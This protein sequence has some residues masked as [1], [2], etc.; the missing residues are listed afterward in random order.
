MSQTEPQVSLPV[1]FVDFRQH[2]ISTACG[3][4]V[5][6][7]AANPTDLNRVVIWC[8]GGTHVHAVRRAL[9]NAAQ[10]KKLPGLILPFIGS[11]R[12]WLFQR[13]PPEQALID[14]ANKQLLLMEAIRQFP[15]L[16]NTANAWL[17]AKELVGLFD[18]CT[19]AQIP[20]HAEPEKL[21]QL[22]TQAYDSPFKHLHNISRE[23]ETIYQ[24]WQAYHAQIRSRN[25][26]DP[27]Q[28]YCN[29]LQRLPE[30]IEQF[31]FYTIGI[32]RLTALETAYFSEL[33]QSHSLTM[34]YANISDQQLGLA[35]HPLHKVYT[36]DTP[37]PDSKQD[38]GLALNLVYAVSM[39]TFKRIEWLKNQFSANPFSNC[40]RLYT[41]HSVENHANAICLQT[42]QWLL[43]E[44]FP[45]GIV[46]NDRLLTRRIRAVLEDA[47][48]SADDLGGWA[49]STTS[50]ATVAEI[51]LDAIESNFRKD[52]LFDLLG[53]PFLA[54]PLQSSP[55]LEQVNR[56]RHQIIRNRSVTRGGISPYI[57]LLES[58][59]NDSSG[60][61]LLEILRSIQ[62]HSKTLLTQSY[63][64]EIELHEFLWQ[65]IQL[66]KK[67]NLT[68]TLA[69]DDAGSIILSTLE[70]ALRSIQDQSIHLG[71]SE[72]RHWLRDLLEH[73][74]F[75]PNRVDR[76]V[77]LCS[78]DH[79]EVQSFSAVIIAGVEQNRLHSQNHSRTF[80]NENVRRELGLQT[81]S[82]TEAIKFIR[83]RQLLEQCDRVLLCAE[84]FCRGEM[85]EISPWVGLLELFSQQAFNQS[86]QDSTLDYGLQ[87]Q[88]ESNM[89]TPARKPCTR[90]AP[91]TPEDLIPTT[92]SA[93]QYQTLLNC[94]Y[95][96]F[97]KYVLN[98][99]PKETAEEF[100]A[101][102]FGRLVHQ[103]L[104]AFHFD[105]DGTTK[106][107][108][109][110]AREILIEELHKIS[111]EMFMRTAFPDA[112]KQG[113]LQRW[114]TNIPAYVDWLISRSEKWVP[115]QGELEIR[116]D[117]DAQCTL[118]GQVDR[119]DY[120]SEGLGLIDFKTGAIPS[121]K[122]VK[123]GETVQLPF[124]GLLND[125]LV[126]A[127]YL[128]LGNA[129]GVSSKVILNQQ[130][131]RELSALHHE[132]LLNIREQLKHNATLPALGSG[133]VCQRCDYHGFCR[134]AHWH[135]VENDERSLSTQR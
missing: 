4:I 25:W 87:R 31:K 19:M 95:Q 65:L 103:S 116:T 85:Q 120:S 56:L 12:D 9:I 69:D 67:L 21:S 109:H 53:N 37:S 13:Y 18:E 78:F 113:W 70:T 133:V 16:F 126:Q 32:H 72:C 28:H 118:Q 44:K 52:A 82:E 27:T 91:P 122:N 108:Q 71:W 117:L 125:R 39:H 8:D 22:L 132:R 135:D 48:I 45:I 74:Y 59:S 81:A 66:L 10:Q 20:L 47:G 42:K 92:V 99:I 76:R 104:L 61:E 68:T 51:I 84:T 50:A 23:S 98:I 89:E 2:V 35:H 26:L 7:F 1:K 86:L 130:E 36:S 124:Y 96:Y 33:Q 3:E 111:T 30:P 49:L 43:E 134:K 73:S 123:L 102:E 60:N 94:P 64:E 29:C 129:D 88:L 121:K 11:L 80:F 24:L 5:G 77:V 114:E 79:I 107:C 97:A 83:F 63:R 55:F 34:Y 105:A 100:D 106:D 128:E 38:R 46:A 75:T 90:P 41:T 115:Q 101:A 58:D 93:T 119:L 54:G 17:L 15:T 131:L 110:T 112:I 62:T 14:E 40:L 6:T 127:E 57:T